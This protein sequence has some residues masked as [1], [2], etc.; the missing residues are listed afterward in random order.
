MGS[1]LPY[2]LDSW[3]YITINGIKIASGFYSTVSKSQLAF[4]SV[5]AAAGDVIRS[6]ERMQ[7]NTSLSIFFIPYKRQ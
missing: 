6:S 4:V 2:D 1:T 5:S 3:G 7:I